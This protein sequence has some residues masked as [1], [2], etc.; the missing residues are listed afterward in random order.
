VDVG[1]VRPTSS[2]S[3]D[4]MTGMLLDFKKIKIIEPR[5]G[6]ISNGELFRSKAHNLYPE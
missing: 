2:A 4:P 3:I 1:F 6:L 5:Q